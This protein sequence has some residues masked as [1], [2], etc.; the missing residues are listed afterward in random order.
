MTWLGR[1]CAARLV[2]KPFPPS[3]LLPPPAWVLR[4]HPV[5][6]RL[7]RP[8]N[9][10]IFSISKGRKSNGMARVESRAIAMNERL[11]ARTVERSSALGPHAAGIAAKTWTRKITAAQDI[12]DG[13]HGVIG[14]LT[15]A[16]RFAS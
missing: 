13:D 16:R 2:A 7:C 3:G 10:M 4:S 5:N 12:I 15:A 11:S 8:G 1:R 6:R 14:N 9:I